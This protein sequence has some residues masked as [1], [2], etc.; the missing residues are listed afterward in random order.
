MNR[1]KAVQYLLLDHLWRRRQEGDPALRPEIADTLKVVGHDSHFEVV[2]QSRGQEQSWRID[3]DQLSLFQR[4]DLPSSQGPVDMS[5]AAA[6]SVGDSFAQRALEIPPASR[7]HPR[8]YGGWER[9]KSTII[10][11]GTGGLLMAFTGP[12]PFW[13]FGAALA[14]LVLSESLGGRARLFSW[15]FVWALVALQAGA[16]ACLAGACLTLTTLLTPGEQGVPWRA[17]AHLAGALAGALVW[18]WWPGGPMHPAAAAALLAAL[19]L[20][21]FQLLHLAPGAQISLV[22]P[23]VSAGLVLDGWG[24]AGCLGFTFSLAEAIWLY[25]LGRV[26][27]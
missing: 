1:E 7:D 26:P 24:L 20:V 5:G 22:W 2:W 9:H 3:K 27:S 16:T 14:G 19:P 8:P 4:G 25:R 17:A 13:G 10:W 12:S 23:L 21:A 18:F 15:C 11:Y 6:R